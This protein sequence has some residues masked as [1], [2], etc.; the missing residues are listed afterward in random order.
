MIL[1]YCP[2]RTYSHRTSI[3]PLKSHVKSVLDDRVRPNTSASLPSSKRRLQSPCVSSLNTAAIAASFLDDRFGKAADCPLDCGVPMMEA[4]LDDGRATAPCCDCLVP[5][6][7]PHSDYSGNHSLSSGAAGWSRETCPLLGFL[8]GSALYWIWPT[9]RASSLDTEQPF[10]DCN[11]F[12]QET[13]IHEI[14]RDHSRNRNQAARVQS[15]RPARLE[16]INGVRTG[17]KNPP[18]WAPV[19]RMLEPRPRARRPFP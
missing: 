17:A 6:K 16:A 3:E 19:F 1:R 15:P 5:P 11:L 2:F 7:G 8:Y 13:Q 12:P 10:F 9:Q 18:T 14:N 4:V